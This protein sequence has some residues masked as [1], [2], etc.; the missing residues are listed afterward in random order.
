M[1]LVLEYEDLRLVKPAIF[2][3]VVKG[4]EQVGAGTPGRGQSSGKAAL[5]LQLLEDLRDGT[6][7][8]VLHL[9][10]LRI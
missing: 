4:E 7:W 9:S 3:H 8:R 6:G 10:L 5:W 1:T 2:P